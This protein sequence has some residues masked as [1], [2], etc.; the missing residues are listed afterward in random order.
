MEEEFVPYELALALKGMGF[1]RKC[2]RHQNNISD[3]IE[4][5]GWLDWNQTEQFV[6][7]PLWQQAF[8]WFA[9]Y[10]LFEWPIESWVQPYLSDQPRRFEAMYWKR[11]ST[12]SIGVYNDHKTANYY[13]LLKLIELGK[14]EQERQK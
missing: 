1:D 4:E 6:S 7:I 9:S 10:N 3:I 8:N 5:K 11:G 12:T 13:R 2:F 14:I